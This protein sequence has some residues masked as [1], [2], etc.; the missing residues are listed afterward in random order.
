MKSDKELIDDLVWN[1]AALYAKD[2]ED[3]IEEWVLPGC[4]SPIERIMAVAL[5]TSPYWPAIDDHD[6]SRQRTGFT[7][8]SWGSKDRPLLE[9]VDDFEKSATVWTMLGGDYLAIAPQ[10]RVLSYRVDFLVVMRSEECGRHIAVVE[11]DGHDYHERTKAQ[12][13]RDKQRDRE[14]QALGYAVLRFTGSEIYKDAAGCAE[15]VAD[16]FWEVARR[17]RKPQRAPT[18]THGEQSA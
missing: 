10:Q 6:L 11:C 14:M 5:F 3:K 7:H 16:H 15:Q 4:E 2:L 18:K 8:P 1:K 12:A 9:M 13:K 17:H